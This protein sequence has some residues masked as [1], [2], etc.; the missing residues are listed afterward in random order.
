[1]LDDGMLDDTG[2]D[3]WFSPRRGV[4]AIIR[5]TGAD[6]GGHYSVVEWHQDPAVPGPLAHIHD[7]EEEAFL[8]FGGTVLVTAGETTTELGP[9]GYAMVPRG[10]PHTYTIAGAEVA[11]F[12]VIL[13]PPGYERFFTELSEVT[14]Q[15]LITVTAE[16]MAQVGARH[17]MRL[18][19]T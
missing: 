1:M 12:L 16:T 13:S 7:G 18:A 9:G 8:V 4:R 6:T 15:G 17:R 2:H 5:A 14:E 10:T 19:P 11:R 3:D